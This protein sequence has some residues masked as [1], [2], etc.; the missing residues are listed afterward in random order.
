MT[1]YSF[2]PEARFDLEEIW[3]FISTEDVDAA[4]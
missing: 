2:H 1:G 3:E 4:D